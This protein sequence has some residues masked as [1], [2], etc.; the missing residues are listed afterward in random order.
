M[1]EANPTYDV[2]SEQAG[3]HQDRADKIYIQLIRSM[4]ADTLA[5]AVK[6]AHETGHKDLAELADTLEGDE[7]YCGALLWGIVKD[8]LRY[9]ADKEAE[10]EGRGE[11]S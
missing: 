9:E 8:Y 2:K 4:D 6:W 10:L 7:A 3:A 11:Q 5:E 1:S